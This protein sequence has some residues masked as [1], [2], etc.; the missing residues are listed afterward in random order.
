MTPK[1]VLSHAEVQ[2]TL[3][4]AQRGKWDIA[5]LAFD[6]SAVGAKACG[7]TFRAATSALI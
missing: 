1:T 6:P 4:I 5:R 3:K 2:G 7:D